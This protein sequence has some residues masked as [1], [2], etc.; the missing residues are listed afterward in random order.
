NAETPKRTPRVHQFSE[1]THLKRLVKMGQSTTDI[2]KEL[3][4]SGSVVSEAIR[5]NK[6]RKVNEV[7]AECL[8]RRLGDNGAAYDILVVK[9]PKDEVEL[10]K[11]MCEKMFNLQTITIK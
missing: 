2:A 5:T 6:W 4:I 3:G 10:F 7:A 11:Q 9:I 1:P 8:C